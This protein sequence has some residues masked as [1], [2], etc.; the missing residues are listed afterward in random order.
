MFGQTDLDTGVCRW[1]EAAAD[2]YDPRGN[3]DGGPEQPE[4]GRSGNAGESGFWAAQRFGQQL[5]DQFDL[6]DR[7]HATAVAWYNRRLASATDLRPSDICCG[8]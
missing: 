8:S 4:S 3:P 6:D 1:D 5:M 2:S 7:I